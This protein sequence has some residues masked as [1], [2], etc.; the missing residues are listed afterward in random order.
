MKLDPEERASLMRLLIDS[1]D[2]ESEDGVDDAWMAE[3]ERRVEE[4]DTG[5]VQS[6][7][8]DEVRARLYGR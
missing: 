2:A 5:A 8:W 4:L 7:P 1:L 6:L 3:I